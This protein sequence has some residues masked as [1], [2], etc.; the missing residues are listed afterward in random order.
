MYTYQVQRWNFWLR[1]FNCEVL[2]ARANL[3]AARRLYLVTRELGVLGST[4]EDYYAWAM[5]DADLFAY[6]WRLRV[7]RK[8]GELA[9]LNFLESRAFRVAVS[10][11]CWADVSL[12]NLGGPT[13][14]LRSLEVASPCTTS[15]DC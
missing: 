9:E 2:D 3:D 13:G 12:Q 1:T 11:Q 10:K 7:D 8:F 5:L 4:H 15:S 6:D 14:S